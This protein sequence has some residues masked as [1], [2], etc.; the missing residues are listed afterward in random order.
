MTKVRI[1]HYSG[2]TETDVIMEDGGVVSISLC[3]EDDNKTYYSSAYYQSRIDKSSE[4]VFSFV[5][6]SKMNVK[7]WKHD[8]I[9]EI[10]LDACNWLQMHNEGFDIT[11]VYI[12]Y[13]HCQEDIKQFIS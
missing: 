1:Y 9:E 5:T 7:D 4:D 6:D 13:E 3:E 2:D 8:N 10:Y 12:P 11:H